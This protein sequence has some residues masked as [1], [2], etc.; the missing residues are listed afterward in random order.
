MT[1]QP[2]TP[3]YATPAAYPAF[4]TPR[5]PQKSFGRSIVGW[6]LFIGLAVMPVLLL[7][8]E[9]GDYFDMALSDFEIQLTSG[10]L[11][12]VHFEGD[13]LW[14][15]F[16]TPPPYT[17]GLVSYRSTLPS[18]MGAQ[19]GFVQWVLNNRGGAIV[20][21]NNNNNLIMQFLLPLIPWA[22]IF[23]FVWFFIFRQLR[24]SAGQPVQPMPVVVVNPQ[25]SA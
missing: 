11:G 2:P 15:Q 24:K 21:V 19:W 3:D 23:L 1:D 17:N 5:P 8:R 22:L 10:N 4:A 25:E 18:G 6:V 16:M 13:A 20:K 9:H 14:G 12:T 7:R